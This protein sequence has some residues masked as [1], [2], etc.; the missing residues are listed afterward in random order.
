M[1]DHEAIRQ[2]LEQLES[3]S[4]T[5]RLVRKNGR[6]LLALPA[7]SD[8]AFR[9][10]RL[11][12][13]QRTASIIFT[14]AVAATTRLGL[15]RLVLPAFRFDCGIPASHRKLPDI[16]SG[17]TTVML[18]SPEHRV[19]RAI[20]CYRTSD[21]W[22][23]AKFAF[24]P[25]GGS[26]IRGESEALRSISRDSP[27]VPR[28]IGEHVEPAL[29][30]LRMPLVEGRMM[31]PGERPDA[32]ELLACWNTGREVEDISSFPEWDSII[33][34]L[35]P[36]PMAPA[37]IDRLSSFR[38]R[39]VVRHGDFARWNLL[40]TTDGQL[41]VLD[42]EWGHPSGMPGIDLVHLFAQDARLVE[43]LAPAAVVASV[44]Q[45]LRAP[46]CL[47][48]LEDV[49]WGDAIDEVIIASVAYTVGASQ[50][51]N[52]AVLDAALAIAGA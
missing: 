34:A 18:G 17:S 1:T 15:H 37:A 19:R 35:E 51:D 28:L 21:R 46:E 5:W 22:E 36:L 43:R 38:L 8:A 32:V 42:W 13:P 47:R 45:S 30:F 12:Q 39:P 7:D 41:T 52:E 24:G 2:I 25:E 14:A 20:T 9:G 23:V 44:R 49:G 40:R 16:A 10:L 31:P 29:S 26:V 4:A 27:G 33:K 6:D 50:Q 3:A 48:Y 11:Y